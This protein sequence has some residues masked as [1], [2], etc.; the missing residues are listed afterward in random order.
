[1]SWLRLASASV[2]SIQ[3]LEL[4]VRGGQLPDHAIEREAEHFQ[5][6][7]RLDLHAHAPIAPRQIRGSLG[8]VLYGQSDA[9][10]LQA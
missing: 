4:V 3:V 9:H 5:L 6:V 2:R 7:T 8:E 1:M 10:C